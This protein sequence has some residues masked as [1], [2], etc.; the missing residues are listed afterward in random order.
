MT[1]SSDAA[2]TF[3]LYTDNKGQLNASMSYRIDDMFTAT[4][5]A[6]NLT[7]EQVI[8]PGIFPGGPT[9]KVLDPGRRFGIGIRARF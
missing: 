8:Q 7:D 3:P 6:N 2:N 1:E 5:S 9:V 4:M